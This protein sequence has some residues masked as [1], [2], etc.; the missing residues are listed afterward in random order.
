MASSSKRKLS[1]CN[2][3]GNKRTKGTPNSSNEEEIAE[4][5]PYYLLEKIPDSICT[6]KGLTAVSNNPFSN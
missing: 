6:A 4:A 1:L 2:T 5:N 3:K